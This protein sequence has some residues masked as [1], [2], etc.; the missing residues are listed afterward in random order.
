MP[1]S[2]VKYVSFIVKGILFAITHK[3]MNIGLMNG[4]KIKK[5]QILRVL[6]LANY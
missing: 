4:E 6:D 1:V 2:F 5:L 3:L